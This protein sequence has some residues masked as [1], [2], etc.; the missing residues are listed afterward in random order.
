MKSFGLTFATEVKIQAFQ[1]F[2]P[3]ADHGAIAGIAHDSRMDLSSNS[4]DVVLWINNFIG[5]E[6]IRALNFCRK[7]IVIDYKG[8]Y[9]NDVR[10]FLLIWTPPSVPNLI[11]SDLC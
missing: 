7:R 6:L 5:Y 8:T 1:A 4:L 11:L 10:R 3:M 9:I 2:V